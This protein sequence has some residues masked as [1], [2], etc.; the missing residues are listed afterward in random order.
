MKHVIHT[1]TADFAYVES[2]LTDERNEHGVREKNDPRELVIA[3]NA[4][5]REV[6]GEDV[7]GLSQ[8]DWNAIL[9]DYLENG[10]IV[11]DPGDIADRM[12][13]AQKYVMNEIK[14]SIKR[15]NNK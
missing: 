4:L 1:P 12:N 9:D 5:V 6:K 3:H 11:G 13:K 15:R 10:E 14:K 7:A 8:V 2:E